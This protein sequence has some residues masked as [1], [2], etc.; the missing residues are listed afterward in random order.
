MKIVYP[1]R[2][3]QLSNINRRGTIRIAE[4]QISYP[5]ERDKRKIAEIELPGNVESLLLEK[6]RASSHID[7]SPRV[8]GSFPLNAELFLADALPSKRPRVSSTT[9]GRSFL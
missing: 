1:T 6:R 7:H 4:F 9:Q 8:Q 5:N 3:D 2:R